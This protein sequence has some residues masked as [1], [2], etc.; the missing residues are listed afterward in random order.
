MAESSYSGIEPHEQPSSSTEWAYSS[1]ELQKDIK[2]LIECGVPGKTRN[3]TK[4]TIKLWIDR[5]TRNSYLTKHQLVVRLKSLVLSLLIFSGC[6][7]LY[8]KLIGMMVSNIHHHHY[9]NCAVIFF[10]ICMLLAKLKS[11]SLSKLSFICLT[12]LW[13]QKWSALVVLVS[14]IICKRLVELITV[15]DE[16]LLWKLGLLGTTQARTQGVRG[17]STEPPIFVVSN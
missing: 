17:D 1:P 3:Q 4:W 2:K 7:D 10:A 6:A 5:A 13:I 9:I 16:S 8:W 11:I 15:E 12:I 14:I